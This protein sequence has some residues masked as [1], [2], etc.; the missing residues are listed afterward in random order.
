M[1]E[2][3]KLIEHLLA[4]GADILCL[5]ISV[6]IAGHI[7]Y[8][9]YEAVKSNV[10]LQ[11]VT[12]VML[13]AYVAMALL[14]NFYRDFVKRGN[15]QELW[16]LFTQEIMFAAALMCLLF[17]IRQGSSISRLMF[18]Y[19]F[20]VHFVLTFVSRLLLKKCMLTI[21]K[22]SK[23]SSR[24]LLVVPL[25][26]AKEIIDSLIGSKEWY[27]QVMGIVAVDGCGDDV[28]KEIGSV[29][30]VATDD[31][32][33]S[34]IT[35]NDIDEVFISDCIE[36]RTETVK[37]WIKTIQQMG[38]V[39][40]VNIDLFNLVHSG[41]RTLNKVGKYATVTFV[42]NLYSTRQFVLKRVLDIFGS[43]IGLLITGIVFP[44]VA[45]AI[46]KDSEGPI[47]FRQTRVGKNGRMFTFN[48][49]RSMYVDAEERKAEL[50]AQNEMSG[51]IF[52]V[53]D[54]P[55]ITKV[56]D[57]LRKTSLDELPQFWNVLKGDMSLV[58]T[59]P[60]TKSEYESYEAKHK[61]RLSMVPGLTGMWQVSG[62]SEIKDFEE[63]IKLDME[64]ID[65][66]NIWK[67]IKILFLTVKVVIMR[68]G[69][70]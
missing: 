28:G 60:P 42:R 3:R 21:F 30:I 61:C 44:F 37:A 47:L 25:N 66:W 14:L 43:I 40:N 55:R 27:R 56:G 53:E 17:M 2:K 50:E 32:L 10:D 13:I 52:K 29:P 39:V 58:G 34:Y 68:K 8:G 15:L 31:N 54:D 7:R 51:P 64:Y 59:R 46:K 65:N 22:H 63:I 69:S 70:K 11:T 12:T 18:G 24:M 4:L 1:Y 16:K 19:Y 6:V 9:D 57:F 35:K 45:I 33:V 26:N 48:K 5:I 67:D 23:Y 62:R 49:F 41:K 36:G 20:M 38:V